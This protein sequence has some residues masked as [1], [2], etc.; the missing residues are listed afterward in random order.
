[1][2]RV[3]HGHTNLGKGIKV[4]AQAGEQVREEKKTM[5][6]RDHTR[7][8]N[9]LW[10]YLGNPYFLSQVTLIIV[11]LLQNQSKSYQVKKKSLTAL[12]GV[13]GDPCPPTPREMSSGKKA[14]AC[15]DDAVGRMP[16]AGT[17]Q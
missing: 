14:P 13:G 17:F 16:S 8:P 5:V 6:R 3:P 9:W 11:L 1:M 4:E 10:H 12:L 15:L 7:K 2:K